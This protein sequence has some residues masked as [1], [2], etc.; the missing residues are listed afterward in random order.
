MSIILKGF[1]SGI[2]LI[3]KGFSTKDVI[4]IFIS[5]EHT[6]GEL[7]ETFPGPLETDIII[8]LLSKGRFFISVSDSIPGALVGT[9]EINPDNAIITLFPESKL[10]AIEGI[11]V[12]G[13]WGCLFNKKPGTIYSSEMFNIDLKGNIFSLQPSVTEGRT[14]SPSIVKITEG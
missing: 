13:L 2:T 7:V 3:T 6:L 9:R 11:Q 14:F 10:E 12:P 1:G 4:P 8:D 5:L